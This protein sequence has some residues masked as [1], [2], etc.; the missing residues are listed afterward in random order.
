M[1]PFFS[2]SRPESGERSSLADIQLLAD[3]ELL[4][5]W[6]QTQIASAAIEARGGSARTAHVYEAA[7]L[8][9]LQRRLSFLPKGSFFGEPAGE[10]NVPDG[11]EPFPH[12]MMVQA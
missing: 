11:P 12:I 10:E 1:M 9:E 6:E 4:N 3:H 7:V 8:L 2:A 5:L